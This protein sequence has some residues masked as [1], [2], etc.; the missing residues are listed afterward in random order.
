MEHL[1]KFD[2]DLTEAERTSIALTLTSALEAGN[3]TLALGS[4]KIGISGRAEMFVAGEKGN[5]MV[6]RSVMSSFSFDYVTKGCLVSEYWTFYLF[7][8]YLFVL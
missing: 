6:V 8:C 1:V 2:H 4:N 7:H 5:V 3:N